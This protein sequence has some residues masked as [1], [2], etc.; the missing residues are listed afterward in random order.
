MVVRDDNGGGVRQERGL[1]YLTG[2]CCGRS[3][4]A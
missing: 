2:L 1:E 3:Y 4:V